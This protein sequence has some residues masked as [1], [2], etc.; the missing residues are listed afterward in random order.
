MKKFINVFLS[1]NYLTSLFLNCLF[2]VCYTR[3]H[4]HFSSQT[5]SH[6]AVN[7]FYFIIYYFITIVLLLNCL[8]CPR[9][10]FTLNN[11]KKFQ[12]SE[13]KLWEE[14]KRKSRERVEAGN[15]HRHARQ[16]RQVHRFV[17]QR[18]IESIR[19]ADET[20]VYTPS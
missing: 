16:Y 19:R 1:V 7:L 6:K 10:F 5:D 17:H 2:I 15:S 8:L 18:C 3:F 13:I 9:G 14:K 12:K 4:Y 11:K 20:E